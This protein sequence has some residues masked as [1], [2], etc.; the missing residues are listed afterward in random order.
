[1]EDLLAAARQ[2]DVEKCRLLIDTARDARQN[3]ECSF[4]IRL[5]Y[6]ALQKRRHLGEYD[7]AKS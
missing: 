6:A 5:G 1:L 2:G 3:L 4:R 7:K